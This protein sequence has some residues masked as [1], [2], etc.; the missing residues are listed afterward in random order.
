MHVAGRR[1]R[2]TDVRSRTA[3]ADPES[4]KAALGS[5]HEGTLPTRAAVAGVGEPAGADSCAACTRNLSRTRIEPGQDARRARSS[6]DVPA[7]SPT[8][9]RGLPADD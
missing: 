5:H 3:R 6:T 7:A 1:A 4:A 2:P 9:A 8:R